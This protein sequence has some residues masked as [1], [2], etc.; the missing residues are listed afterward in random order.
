MRRQKNIFMIFDKKLRF[1]LLVSIR[2]ANSGKI[3]MDNLLATLP[4]EVKNKE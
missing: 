1:A 4:A 2:L 3:Q